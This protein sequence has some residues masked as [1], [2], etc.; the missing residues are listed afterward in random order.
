M[1]GVPQSGG[2]RPGDSG[3]RGTLSAVVLCRLPRHPDR[4]LTRGCPEVQ[5][6]PTPG[7]ARSPAQRDAPRIPV[8]E[9]LRRPRIQNDAFICPPER[10]LPP[11]NLSL[12]SLQHTAFRDHKCDYDE[13]ISVRFRAGRD[14]RR[15]WFSHQTLNGSPA[16]LNSDKWRKQPG[17]ERAQQLSAEGPPAPAGRT[18]REGFK[19]TWGLISPLKVGGEGGW[20]LTSVPARAL[21]N[22]V[23]MEQGGGPVGHDE[24]NA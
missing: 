22:K 24:T 16:A 21:L 7:P 19:R 17:G 1:P 13:A 5:G 9:T 3:Y 6:S 2:D 12:Q 8:A 15:A 4:G 10:G 20:I 23:L 11:A 18:G 14:N